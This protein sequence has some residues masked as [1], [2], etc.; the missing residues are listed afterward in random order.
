GGGDWSLFP[1]TTTP[2]GVSL[3][4]VPLQSARGRRQSV[5]CEDR[6]RA[7]RCPAGDQRI[8]CAAL[9]RIQLRVEAIASLSSRQSSE[10]FKLCEFQRLDIRITLR[11]RQAF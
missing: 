7:D 10:R 2:P 8:G 6:S 4:P 9:V 11:E 5:S 3:G 1:Q